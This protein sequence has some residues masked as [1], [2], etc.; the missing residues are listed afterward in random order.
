MMLRN[1]Q[2]QVEV[3][4]EEILFLLLFY[5]EEWGT[6]VLLP[7]NKTPQQQQN[8]PPHTHIYIHTHTLIVWKV[9][10]GIKYRY[11]YL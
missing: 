8:N 3:K 2:N 9:N 10:H 11:L 1:K 7:K 4:K 5:K 6:P